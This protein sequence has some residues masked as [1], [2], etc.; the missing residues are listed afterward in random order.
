MPRQP[1]KRKPK[2]TT[3]MLAAGAECTI[4][5]ERQPQNSQRLVI[6]DAATGKILG[7]IRSLF[8]IRSL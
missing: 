4:R 3:R 6:L 2:Q 5:W 1:V 7:V 8:E